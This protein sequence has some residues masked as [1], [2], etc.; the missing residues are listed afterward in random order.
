MASDNNV[1]FHSMIS[2]IQKVA[3]YETKTKLYLLGSNDQETRFRLLQIDRTH[4][5]E[6]IIQEYPNEMEARGIRKLVSSWG[7]YKLTSA[8]GILGFVRFLEGYYLILV[9]KRTRIGIVGM[10]LLYTIMV[11]H[12]DYDDDYG[13]LIEYYYYYGV[14]YYD[15]T[16]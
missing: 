9:T 14:G 7:H 10:H 13:T 16:R 8:Y 11:W 15:D 2:S 12:D 4:P 5:N 6:L 3:L 1:I